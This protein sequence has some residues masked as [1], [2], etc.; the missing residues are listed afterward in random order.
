MAK[1]SASL[2]SRKDFSTTRPVFSTTRPL[3]ST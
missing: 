3:S 2:L 1:I